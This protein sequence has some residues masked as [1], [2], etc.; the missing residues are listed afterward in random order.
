MQDQ[1]PEDEVKEEPQ[2]VRAILICVLNIT[3]LEFWLNVGLVHLS[4]WSFIMHSN[5][6]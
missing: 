1:Y 2:A 4:L 5:K 6:Y 3:I